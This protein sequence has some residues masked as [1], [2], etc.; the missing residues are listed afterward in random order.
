[1]AGIHAGLGNRDEALELL[2][3]AATERHRELLTLKLTPLFADLRDD[4][5]YRALLEQ[6]GLAK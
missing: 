4:P 6:T 5:R 1:M 3:R 2:E